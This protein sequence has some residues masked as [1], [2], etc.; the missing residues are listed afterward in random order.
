MSGVEGSGWLVVFEAR[1]YAEAGMVRGLLEAEGIAV[2]TR[3]KYGLPQ[4][5]PSEPMLVLVDQAQA[6]LAREL[7]AA[8]L[9]TPIGG[10]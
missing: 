1:N 2:L 7:L 3:G 8:Y 5:G 6:G 10:R 4:L 9:E